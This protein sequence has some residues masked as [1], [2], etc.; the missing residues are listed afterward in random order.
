MPRCVLSAAEAGND[1]EA[2]AHSALGGGEDADDVTT[3]IGDMGGGR[4]RTEEPTTGGTTTGEA[5]AAAAA[6]GDADAATGDEAEGP[7]SSLVAA[8]VG[9]SEEGGPVNGHPQP[10]VCTTSLTSPV[11]GVALFLHRSVPL[12]SHTCRLTSNAWLST[13]AQLSHFLL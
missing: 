13:A 10:L 11:H 9:D 8:T 4:G 1:S 3:E 2:E 6:K 12:L 5:A 7:Q